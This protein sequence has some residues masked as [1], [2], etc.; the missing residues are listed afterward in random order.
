MI[1]AELIGDI[2]ATAD[3]PRPAHW[4]SFTKPVV[5]TAA[6][7]LVD[8]GKLALDDALAGK[9]Y[10]LRHL[11]Q[12]R[13]GVPN[14]T[15]L[16]AYHN[17]VG[18]G[19]TP[20][21]PEELL[22]RVDADT[23]DFAPEQGWRYSNTGYLIVRQ[24]IEGATGQAIAAAL[25]DLVLGPLGVSATVAQTPDDLR[26]TAWGNPDD[27]HPGWVYHGLLIGSAAD[28]VTLLHR[29][30]TGDLLPPALRAAMTDHH[31]L[32]HN[33][34]GRPW[35]AGGYGLGLMAGNMAADD[36]TTVEVLAQGHSGNGPGS[37]CA[38]YHFP[39]LSPPATFGAFAPAEDEDDCEW[40]AAHRALAQL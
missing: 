20:W 39:H 5:A 31:H 8:Q 36:T 10:T 7:R 21:T 19:D 35:R 24:L 14:Y 2:A 4:W 33:I 40:H 18:R 16:E 13:A 38:V 17:A 9:P 27:Y 12:H 22:A 6:L 37:V 30:L 34:P 25:Q 23:L 29:L 32:G 3:D 28:A 15:A 11:L 1:T 26:A